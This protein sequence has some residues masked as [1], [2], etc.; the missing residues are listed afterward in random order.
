MPPAPS[1]PATASAPQPLPK[2]DSTGRTANGQ[3][4]KGNPGGPGNPFA[5]QVAQL[6]RAALAA[7]TPE[8]IAE[9]I[10]QV[11]IRAL[12]GDVAAAKLYLSYTLG[13]PAMA[14]DPDTLD[15]QEAVQLHKEVSLLSGVTGA[16]LQLLLTALLD[17]VRVS[18]P[19]A[20]QKFRRDLL[21]G[22]A[23]QDEAD[24]AAAQAEPA[25]DTDSPCQQANPA[26]S[27]NDTSGRA[28]ATAPRTR[29]H[30]RVAAV[31]T[32]RSHSPEAPKANG[33]NGEPNHGQP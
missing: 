22:F 24:R 21:A 29:P 9:V 14:V 30:T 17:M 32:P 33:A 15:V 25:A 28:P 2:D 10:R 18:R 23:A 3:F 13:R 20:T 19:E 6:R 7:T 11:E 5:R 31:P 1:C 12:E 26:A 4:A 27:T 16:L 8:K